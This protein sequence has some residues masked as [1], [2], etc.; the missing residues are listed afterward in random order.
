MLPQAL[1]V[2]AAWGFVYKTHIAWVKDKDGTGYWF[3]NKHPKI[4]PCSLLPAYGL[5]GRGVRGLRA[6][7]SEA[8]ISCSGFPDDGGQRRRRSHSSEGYAG[9]L[10][11]AGGNRPLA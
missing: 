9:D 6:L 7:Q 5:P 1:E 10:D 3:R 2:M 8:S 11:D 4:G